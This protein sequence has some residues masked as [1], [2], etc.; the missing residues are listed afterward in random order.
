LVSHLPDFVA[1]IKNIQEL[2]LSGLAWF[3]LNPAGQINS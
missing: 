3:V 2:D 1:K